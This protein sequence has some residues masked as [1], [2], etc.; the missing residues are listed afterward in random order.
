[1]TALAFVLA[2]AISFYVGYKYKRLVEQ[3]ESLRV[4]LNKKQDKKTTRYT[5][6]TSD[7]V[8]DPFDAVQAAKFE[9]DILM[10]KLNPEAK[11][12]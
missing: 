11:D 5:S 2:I 6:N 3:I 10:K 8:I 1:M 12:D 7:V 4:T 9:H